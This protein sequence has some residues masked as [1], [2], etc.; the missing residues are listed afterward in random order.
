MQDLS[1]ELETAVN[2]VV[3]RIREEADL[4]C[5]P[6]DEE[7][8]EFLKNLPSVPTNPTLH[9]DPYS[10]SAWPPLRDLPFERLCSLAKAARLRDLQLRPEA[11]REWE[12]AAA[13]LQLNRHPM[14]WLLM[15]SGAKK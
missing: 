14:S 15:W 12:F 5:S 13:V 3:D 10:E 8:L 2:F 7:E 4:I 6:L 11:S 1:T 9:N